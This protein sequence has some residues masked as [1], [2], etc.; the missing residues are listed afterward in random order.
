MYIDVNGKIGTGGLRGTSGKKYGHMPAYSEFEKAV[1]FADGIKSYTAPETVP[2]TPEQQRESDA[3]LIRTQA[4]T[5]IDTILTLDERV[6]ALA[7]AVDLLDGKN[8]GRPDDPTKE[9]S[10]KADRDAINAIRDQA[11]LDIAAL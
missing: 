7:D 5:D 1:I 11:A 2:L 3:A 8:N 10:L 9:A 6:Q 4:M